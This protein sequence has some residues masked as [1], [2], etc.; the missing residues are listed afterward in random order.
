MR[1]IDQNYTGGFVIFMEETI[2]F[3]KKKAPTQDA[4]FTNRENCM[5]RKR[6]QTRRRS[7]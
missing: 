2:Q 5:P 3:L 7:V 6:L 4:F 1:Q